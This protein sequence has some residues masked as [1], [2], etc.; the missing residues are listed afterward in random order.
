MKSRIGV[1]NAGGEAAVEGRPEQ[2]A[3]LAKGECLGSRLGRR[4]VLGGSATA[5]KLPPILP[6]TQGRSVLRWWA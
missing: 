6:G 5:G 1:E 3:D 2:L 4:R